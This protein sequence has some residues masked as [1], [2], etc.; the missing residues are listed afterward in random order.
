M[1][2]LDR[3]DNAT[4]LWALTLPNVPHPPNETLI[5]W[6]AVYSD[7]EYESTLVQIP[8][9][10]RNFDTKYGAVVPDK[11]YRLISSFLKTERRERQNNERSFDGRIQ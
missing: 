2:F 5:G 9:R 8:H 1:K 10:I 3:F 11:I 6:L 7:D 4:K